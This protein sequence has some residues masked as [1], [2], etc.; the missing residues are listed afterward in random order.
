MLL[1]YLEALV[2]WMERNQ[3]QLDRWHFPRE[4]AVQFGDLLGLIAAFEEQR[5][6]MPMGPWHEFTSCS[7]CVHCSTGSPDSYCGHLS[8][9]LLQNGTT[10]KFQVV[11][12]A[13]APA[14]PSSLA[15]QGNNRVTSYCGT[16]C[17]GFPFLS[18]CWVS[19]LKPCMAAGL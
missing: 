11:Q 2:V 5:T 7:S 9:E 19:F 6:V 16:S 3:L 12:N 13:A 18:R 1:L 17:T 10:W 15:Q 14:I 8:L 4:R